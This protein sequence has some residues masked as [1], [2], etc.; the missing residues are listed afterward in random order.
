[1]ASSS[2]AGPIDYIDSDFFY[3]SISGTSDINLMRTTNTVPNTINIYFTENLPGLCGISSFTFSSVQGIAMANSCA[4]LPTNPSTFSHELG[5]DF[6]L[7]HTHE[8]FYGDECVNGSNCATAGD[9]VSDTPPIR[10]WAHQR[11]A[12]AVCTRAVPPILA[13]AHPMSCR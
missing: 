8:P 12:R 11:S 2:A 4:G 5:H 1:M 3:F 10:G 6:D 13:A 7:F 9:L